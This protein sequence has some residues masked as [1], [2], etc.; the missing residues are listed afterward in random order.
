MPDVALDA[1]HGDELRAVPN[2]IDQVEHLGKAKKRTITLDT[3]AAFADRVSYTI[4]PANASGNENHFQGLAVLADGEHYIASGSNWKTG[5][6]EVFS[7]QVPFRAGTGTSLQTRAVDFPLWHTGGIGCWGDLIALPAECPRFGDDH[8][9]RMAGRAAPPESAV[10]CSTVFFCAAPRWKCCR[11]PS[12]S[13][14][15]ASWPPARA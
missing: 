13:R 14:D 2:V 4:D 11:R 6:G 1:L 12:G 15:P 10:N 5:C 7:F 8:P 9:G 3:Q